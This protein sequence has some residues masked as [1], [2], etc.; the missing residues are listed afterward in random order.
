MILKFS[1]KTLII[2]RLLALNL[3]VHMFFTVPIAFLYIE[4]KFN[5]K[6]SLDKKVSTLIVVIITSTYNGFSYLF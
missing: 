2:R 6:V 4:Y 3:I 5:Y 1:N